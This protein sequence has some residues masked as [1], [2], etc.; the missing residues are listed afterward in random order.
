[1]I[2]GSTKSLTSVT[3][4]KLC[5]SLL[6]CYFV[7]KQAVHKSKLGSFLIH[8]LEGIKHSV[9]EKS[10][11]ELSTSLQSQLETESTEVLKWLT[12]KVA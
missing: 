4:Y 5:I 11:E 2:W 7:R 6:I 8:Q 9:Q 10:W 12:K 3:P 1:M